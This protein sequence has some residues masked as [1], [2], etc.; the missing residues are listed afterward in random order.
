[1]LGENIFKAQIQF[2][3]LG[4]LGDPD[5]TDSCGVTYCHV[6]DKRD[7]DFLPSHL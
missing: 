7:S 3:V 4:L 6:T 5:D 2:Y 1:M